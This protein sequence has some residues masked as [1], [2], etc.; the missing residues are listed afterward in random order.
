MGIP[1]IR[2]LTFSSLYW[3]PLFR[4][5]TNNDS[6][7]VSMRQGYLFRWAGVERLRMGDDPL[8]TYFRTLKSARPND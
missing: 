1:I 3:V 2:I 5:T 7:R 8:A 4:E 6:A